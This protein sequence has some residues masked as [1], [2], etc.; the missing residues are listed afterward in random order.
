MR[1]LP[2]EQ[3]YVIEKDDGGL[4]QAHVANAVKSAEFLDEQ[5]LSFDRF[6]YGRVNPWRHL[7]GQKNKL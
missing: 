1:Y 3:K 5:T 4:E 2:S 7:L 6:S